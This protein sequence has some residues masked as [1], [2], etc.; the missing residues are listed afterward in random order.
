MRRRNH[1]VL[2]NFNLFVKLIRILYPSPYVCAI[3][4][5][6]KLDRVSET[7]RCENRNCRKQREMLLDS[8]KCTPLPVCSCGWRGCTPIRK[9][10]ARTDAECHRSS[11]P[12]VI[13][14]NQMRQWN[15][16]SE[17]ASFLLGTT[18]RLDGKCLQK[19]HRFFKGL[20]S[21]AH[22]SWMMNFLYI[23]TRYA[24]RQ[25]VFFSRKKYKC[26][27]QDFSTGNPTAWPSEI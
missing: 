10:Q 2:W 12:C 23:G 20:F 1:S 27:K 14:N 11:S 15:L 5:D 6:R 24:R 3:R 9:T 4:S 22:V 26:E 7:R 8:P 25:F 16:C 19:K 13:W 18:C 17:S 21:D